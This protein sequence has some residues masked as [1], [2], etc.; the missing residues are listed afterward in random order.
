[1]K[2]NKE[3]SVAS[4][5]WGGT[6]PGWKTQVPGCRLGVGLGKAERKATVQG[7]RVG[8]RTFKYL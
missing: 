8:K 5:G 1:M 7:Y 2:E 4:E 6:S 3:V